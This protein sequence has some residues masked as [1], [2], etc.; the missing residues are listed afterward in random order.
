MYNGVA[1][2]Y[3]K[4]MRLNNFLRLSLILGIYYCF[5]IVFAP[6]GGAAR[7][8]FDGLSRGST[9]GIGGM[10]YTEKEL[11]EISAANILPESEVI[12]PEP[13]EFSAPQTLLYSSY[14]IQSGDMIGFIAENFGLNQGTLVSINEIKNTRQIY[15]N[16]VLK[17]PNQDGIIHKVAPQETLAAIAEKYQVE[18]AALITANELFSEDVNPETAI[19]IPGA[20]LDSTKLQEINGD[21]FIWPIR[22]RITSRYGYR[23]S[24]IS[25]LRTF[26]TGIDLSA[27][28]G[29]PIKAAMSGRVISAGYNATFGN[30]I[31]ISHHSNYRTLYGH[32]SAFKTKSGAYVRTGEVIGYVGNTGQSTGSHLHFTVYKNGVTVNPLLLMN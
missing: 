10:A 20:K 25:G 6:A 15:P 1:M 14:K 29:V 26:H 22:G 13:L 5:Q 28:T 2:R 30:Y 9:P 3:N 7:R 24:P 4:K 18:P 17:I 21:L 11:A 19:F 12:I 27:I 31:V 32:L 16:E 23:I 8:F